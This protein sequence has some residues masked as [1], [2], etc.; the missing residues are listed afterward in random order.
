MLRHLRAALVIAPVVFAA[1]AAGAAVRPPRDAVET[2]LTRWIPC[3]P[4]E[5]CHPAGDH[6]ILQRLHCEANPDLPGQPQ[7]FLCR[8][9][10]RLL[11]G[12]GTPEPFGLDCAYLWR[13]PSGRWTVWSIPDGDICEEVS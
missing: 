11:H 3:A 13:E 6:V 2:A 7:R 8:F 5:D 9:R 10:A 12:D 1:S 4:D